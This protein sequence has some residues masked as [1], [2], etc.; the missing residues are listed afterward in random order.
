MELE[1]W[2]SILSLIL[3][4]AKGLL[5]LLMIILIAAAALAVVV[6]SGWGL[7]QALDQEVPSIEA[8]NEL[9]TRPV[10]IPK[11]EEGGIPYAL[12]A[13]LVPT[14]L[15]PS[16]STLDL[17]FHLHKDRVFTD[18]YVQSSRRLFNDAGD[19][20]DPEREQYQNVQAQLRIATPFSQ[21]V[22]QSIPLERLKDFSTLVHLPLDGR[23]NGYPRDWYQGSAAVTVILPESLDFIPLGLEQGNP[24]QIVAVKLSI[25]A[26]SN[27][28][29]A[30]YY[31]LEHTIY[32][33]GPS[34]PELQEVHL[35]VRRDLLNRTFVWTMA[36]I[37]LVLILIAL[38]QISQPRRR[39]EGAIPLEA[40]A[41]LAILPLRQVLVP[42]EIRG[43]TTID[44]ILGTELAVFIGLIAVQYVLDHFRSAQFDPERMEAESPKPP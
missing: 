2:V 12:S 8:S 35:V 21:D 19:M 33:N 40:I 26:P 16:N 41:V 42:P 6:I 30:I 14:Q 25:R 22:T 36:L 4:R 39:A 9:N 32:I 1:R 3:Q 38:T 24:G 13:D 7:R 17:M 11:A 29:L 10:S 31:K 23:P 34:S 28:A 37:P 44:F 15:N 20:N 27:T 43:L 18:I 5:S